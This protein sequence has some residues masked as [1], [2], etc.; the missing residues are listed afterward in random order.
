MS[1]EPEEVDVRA[2]AALTARA[3]REMA[4]TAHPSEPW[5]PVTHAA[6]GREALDVLVVGAGQGGAAV[7]FGLLRAN[8]SR[9]LVIDRASRGREGPWRT[10]ARMPTLRSPKEFT[11]PDLGL[12]SLTCQAWHEACFGAASWETLALIDRERWQQY[13]LWVRDTT[14]VPVENDTALIDLHPT[15]DGLLLATLCGPAGERT[16]VARKVVLASGQDGAG[17]WVMPDFIEALPVTHRAHAADHIDFDALRGR[18]VAVLGAGASAMDNAA[19]ALEHGAIE[20]HLYVRRARMQRV[21]PYRW[22]TFNGF[23]EHLCHLDDPWR[24]RFM[25]RVLSMRESIPPDTYRRARRFDNFHIHV[26]ATWHDA[27][28]RDGHVVLDTGIGE[29]TADFVICG[30]GIDIDPSLKPELA[31]I[32]PQIRTWGDAC[33]PPPGEQDER[34]ARYPY[35]D[36]WGAYTERAPGTAPWLADIHDFT[37]AATMSFGPSGCSINAMTTAVPRLVRGI[38]R[39]LFRADVERHWQRFLDYDTPIFELEPPDLDK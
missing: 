26:G 9:I 15:D 19:T 2:L 29:Q 12:P 6:D 39:G 16:V 33:E 18:R 37:I 27:C 4:M 36:E 28:V 34:L 1:G 35:L 5:M 14:N 31:S 22:I 3:R 11:G 10:F 24:W 17:Q 25:Q 32:A 20:V 23:L 7:G 8:V 38:T 30:T 21:Q 13:L